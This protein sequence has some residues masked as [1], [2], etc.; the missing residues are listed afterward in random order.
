MLRSLSLCSL[1]LLAC[2]CS[3]TDANFDELS[4]NTDSENAGELEAAS[5]TPA[6][7]PLNTFRFEDLELSFYWVGPG[8][9][10]SQQGRI[11]IQEVFGSADYV[12]A[13]Q[14]QYG[15][16]TSL[17]I[18]NAFAPEGLEP[19]PALVALHEAEASAQGRTG[20]ELG[21]RELDVS[22]LSTEKAIPA[23]CQAQV[24]PDISPG[25]YANIQTQ[26][27]GA[28]GQYFYL[29]AGASKKSGSVAQPGNSLGCVLH[30]N[31]IEL[32]VGICN[33]TAS[34]NTT[35][36][37]TQTNNPLGRTTTQRT[38]VPVGKVGRFTIPPAHPPMVF[39][40]IIGLGVIGRNSTANVA[41][42]HRQHSG[43]GFY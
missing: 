27:V 2:A 9:I 22:A 32:T 30:R 25:L 12:R 33:D 37:W 31:D 8:S 34:T 17:E 10:E 40:A 36:F 6:D 39:D 18:F 43:L 11:G 1:F 19:H 5:N 38:S 41:N 3:S 15:R 16:A 21:V 7:E 23:N 35:E 42:A 26:N 29:C 20:D 28:D 4:A 24:L 13:L 14:A